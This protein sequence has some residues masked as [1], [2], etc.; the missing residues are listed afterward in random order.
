MD[1]IFFKDGPKFA[2]EQIE[3]I[4]SDSDLILVAA[5][6]NQLYNNRPDDEQKEE[7]LRPFVLA[8]TKHEDR[9]WLVA[10]NGLLWRSRNEF[11]RSKTKEKA[12]VFMQ[13]VL[14]KFRD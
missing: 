9:N 11:V 8:L 7:M 4:L 1:D 10:H 6:T 5:Q 13:G 2:E 14:D 3:K 12:Q